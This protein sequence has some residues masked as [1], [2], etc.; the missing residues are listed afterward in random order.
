MIRSTPILVLDEATANVDQKTDALIQQTLRGPKFAGVTV[1][2]VAH[3][4]N[5]IIDYDWV[6]VL[7]EGRVVESGPPGVLLEKE[8]G[9]FAN[10]VAFSKD[11][12]TSSSG[13]RDPS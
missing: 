12:G 10:M 4:L 9:L 6:L 7:D 1:L 2:S 5:T 8:E 3:R 11:G 13:G